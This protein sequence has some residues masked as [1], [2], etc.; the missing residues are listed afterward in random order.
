MDKSNTLNIA[1]VIDATGSMS[2]T[3]EALKPALSQFCRILPLFA[4][5]KFYLIIY[6]DFDCKEDNIYKCNGPFDSGEIDQ[7]I[8]ILS[9]TIATGG[10]DGPECQKYAF[11]MLLADIDNSN[12]IVYHFTDAPPHQFPFPKSGSSDNA[13]REGVKINME[14]MIGDWCKLSEIFQQKSI[15]VYTIGRF[16]PA[17]RRYYSYLSEMTGSDSVLLTNTSV[18]TI[19]KATTSIV[20]RSLGYAECNL[21]DLGTIIRIKDFD[22][23]ST[24]DS[25]QFR[26]LSMMEI[27]N[28]SDDDKIDQLEL[29]RSVRSDC[30]RVNLETR[31]KK[32]VS[33]RKTCYSTFESLIAD[34]HILSLTY[35]PLV[36][37]LYRQMCK[38]TSNQEFNLLRDRLC[39]MMSLTMSKL[40]VSNKDAYDEVSVWIENSYNSIEEINDIIMQMDAPKVPF[41]VL[42]TDFRPTKK[43]LTNA[44]TIPLPQNLKSLFGIISNLTVIETKPRSMPEVFVPLNLPAEQLFSMISHLVCPGVILER[45]GIIILSII[46]LFTKNSILESKALEIMKTHKGTWF[47]PEMSEYYLL[48]FIKTILA[49]YKS[50]PNIL[51]EPEVE[52]MTNLVKIGVLKQNNYTIKVERKM[53]LRSESKT[54]YPDHKSKCHLCNQYRSCSVTTSNGCGLCLSYNSDELSKLTDDDDAK[55]Y[56]FDCVICK[57]RYAVRNIDK[58]TNL[59]RC[60]YCRKTGITISNKD[61][62]IASTPFVAC[63]VCSCKIVLPEG[64][65][66]GRDSYICALCAS[67]N[68]KEKTEVIEVRIH[69]VIKYNPQIISLITGLKIDA[70]LIIDRGKSLYSIHNKYALCT[71]PV[72]PL[73]TLLCEVDSTEGVFEIYNSQEVLDELTQLVEKKYVKHE[74][75]V[76]CFNDFLHHDLES[77]CYRPKCSGRACRPCIS[78][79]FESNHPG[80]N[81]LQNRLYCP[82]CK[83]I[84]VSG[85]AFTNTDLKK[86]YQLKPKFDHDWHYAWCKSCESVVEYMER[87]CAGPDPMDINDFMCETCI[88]PNGVKSCPFCGIKT[89]KSSGCDHIEC[90]TRVGGCGA[91]WCYRCG[92]FKSDNA[93]DVY[94]HLH[95]IH[96]NIYGVANEI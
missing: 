5:S 96:G 12:L 29:V 47:K 14:D 21:K 79:W 81:I 40:K 28:R 6:R 88:N 62:F 3:L 55:S 64:N 11:N 8:K 16:C 32:D 90:P 80:K 91:H 72:K 58:M 74:T 67:N 69:D 9:A 50:H 24:E 7:M 78:R 59:P 63:S 25:S 65:D 31:F 45:K 94:D 34:G 2:S 85:I 41:I 82:C 71:D 75:C 70:S 33:F 60:H 86:I 4:K 37:C 27:C 46:S 56:L 22:L 30:N 38:K 93:R 77:L 42:Q 68:E 49:V 17:S 57:G 53:I 54:L 48:G 23:I 83:R 76:I 89:S 13:Y 39:D 35:N 19:L 92:E 84:P 10:G 1:F 44:C 95:E 61:T 20:T 66:L 87:Q 18:M 51:F 73:I 15:P 36:G 52:E 26:N 43:E